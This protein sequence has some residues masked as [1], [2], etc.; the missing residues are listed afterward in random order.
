[1][2]GD[3]LPD[4]GGD[5]GDVE[6]S[7]ELV[8]DDRLRDVHRERQV[9]QVVVRLLLIG[10]RGPMPAATPQ[11]PDDDATGYL[12]QGRARTPCGIQVAPYLL[13]G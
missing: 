13:D 2:A 12:V 3:L 8:S 5:F 7:R 10:G 6:G 4:D 9:D 11:A 1:M